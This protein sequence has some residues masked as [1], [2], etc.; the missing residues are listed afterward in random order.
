MFAK[1]DSV[2]I[3][4]TTTVNSAS[5]VSAIS[6]VPKYALAAL[7]NYSDLSPLR[8]LTWINSMIPDF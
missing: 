3:M 6:A 5:L 8:I 2:S 4:S 1:T 7:P